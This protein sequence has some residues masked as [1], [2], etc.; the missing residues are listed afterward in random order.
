MAARSGSEGFW[1]ALFSGLADAIADARHK[2]VEE[3]WFG[4]QVT[5][6]EPPDVSTF[7][8][9]IQTAD[10]ESFETIWGARDPTVGEQAHDPTLE[11][12]R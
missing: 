10:E 1:D 3:G 9:P 8:R 11:Y 6:N 4:R 7:Y 2:V 12:D 5:P